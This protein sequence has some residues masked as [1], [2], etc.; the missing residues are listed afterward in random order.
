MSD[1]LEFY[2]GHRMI[3]SSDSSMVPRVGEFI[4]IRKA[5]WKIT[6]IT[7]ALDHAD[8]YA[9]CGMRCNVDVKLEKGDEK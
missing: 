3:G 7:Y 4:S 6:N 2:N 8:D 1:R 5:T 9:L